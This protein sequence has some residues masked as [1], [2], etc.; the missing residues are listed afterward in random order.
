MHYFVFLFRDG[1][2]YR[3]DASIARFIVR[4]SDKAD[5]LFGKDIIEQAEVT[6]FLCY[7][8]KLLIFSFDRF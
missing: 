4:S 7:V 8:I 6:T 3:N 2:K 5:D 1:V